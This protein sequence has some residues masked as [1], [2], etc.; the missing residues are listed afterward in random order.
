MRMTFFINNNDRR[1]CGLLNDI[2]AFLHFHARGWF[3]VREEDATE[4]NDGEDEP[5][6]RTKL[7]VEFSDPVDGINF[8]GWRGISHRGRRS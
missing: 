4:E 7:T 3:Q 1:P 6:P 8:C 2:N 5:E